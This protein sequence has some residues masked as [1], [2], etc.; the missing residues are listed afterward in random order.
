MTD[1]EHES[2]ALT[3]E[4]AKRTPL[5]IVRDKLLGS[6]RDEIQK[7]LPPGVSVD[8]FIRTTITVVQMNPELLQ[9]TSTSFFGS[10][11]AAAKD[12]LLPDGRE[13][14]IQTYNCNVA[15]NGQ[16]KRWEKRAQYMPMVRG[17]IQIMYRSG[18][19]KM[20]D[21][22][23]VY[24]R[25]EFEYE[26]G[27]APRIIHKPYGG[28]EHPGPIVAAYCI[29]KLN[30]GEVKREVMFKR[31]LDKVREASSASQGPG[32]KNWEDQFCIKAVIKRAFKQLDSDSQE[33]FSHA[34][35]ADNE[36]MGFDFNHTETKA[37][38]AEARKG[39]LSSGKAGEPNRLKAIIGGSK[40]ADPEPV[41]P[42]VKPEPD[43][44]DDIGD[45]E[46]IPFGE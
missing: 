32:W 22:V 34:I 36:A 46:D 37:A 35:Q 40:A 43:N 5:E 11:M 31:D 20:V 10:I 19:V 45:I 42:E 13:A 6:Q 26:R 4:P 23:A 15:A 29:I 28:A 14:V 2:N 41:E 17:L 21:G 44:L 24:E 9:C 39:L 38:A 1:I 33:L 30:N 25:D 12:G 3:T 16:P 8:R 27:D 7:Q 18:Q